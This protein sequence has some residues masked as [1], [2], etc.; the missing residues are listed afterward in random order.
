[1]A[2]NFLIIKY[3]MFFRIRSFGLLCVYVFIMNECKC[4]FIERF[5]LKLV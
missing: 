2:D 3:F 1:M 5:E 4:D